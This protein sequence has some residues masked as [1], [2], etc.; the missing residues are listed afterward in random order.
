MDMETGHLLWLLGSL[1]QL[2]RAP[3]D[4]Q[5]ARLRHPG[6]SALPQVLDAI[7]GLGLET[8]L[9]QVRQADAEQLL[10]PCVLFLRPTE[11]PAAPVGSIGA[12]CPAA[13]TPHAPDA[14][15][16]PVHSPLRPC[17]VVR[18]SDERF[19]YF[20]AGS[21]EPKTGRY[22][23]FER[24]FF[25]EACTVRRPPPHYG[26][27]HGSDPGTDEAS[28]SAPRRFGFR[29]FI[30]RLLA[31]RAVWRD[32][33][34]ASL[35]LQ[36]AGLA[37][38]LITQAILDKVI[39]HHA[40]NT[41][42][43]L[44]GALLM[45]LLF[46]AGMGYLRQYLMLH[47]GMRVDAVLASETFSHLVRLPPLYF[48]H[49]PAG[50]LVARLQ[51]IES[52][53]E[54]ISGA[55][56]AAILDLPFALLILA[57]MLAYSPALT[58]LAAAFV[59]AMAA[60]GLAIAP[61]LRRRVEAQF[62]DSARVQ[63]FLTEH[64]SRMAPAKVLQMEPLLARRHDGLFA[65]FLDSGFATRRL[66]AG[67][68]TL[69]SA[70]EQG[71][72]LSILAAGAWL[73]MS[74]PGFTIGMLIAFQMFAGRLSQPVLRLASLWQE[75][76]QAALAVRRLGDFMDLPP[77][78]ET[79]PRHDAGP[80][81]GQVQVENLG[82]RHAASL[83]WLYRGLNLALAP[84]RCVLLLGPSGSGKS[85]LSRLLLGYY[86]PG[87]GRILL[88]GRDITQQGVERLRA[89]FGVVPQDTTLFS[90]SVLDNLLLANPHASIQDA[91][92]A[93]QM[94]GVHEV[95][96]AQPR[97][98]HSEL[99]EGGVGLSG[100]QRQRIAIARALLK[101]ARLLVLDE[102]L[103]GLDPENA[104]QIIATLNR[105]VSQGVGLL[106]IAHE[107]PP[108]LQVHQ[109]LRLQ[110]VPQPPASA[111]DGSA[112]MPAKP[113]PSA[114]ACCCPGAGRL[115]GDGIPCDEDASAS[116][117]IPAQAGIHGV[118]IQN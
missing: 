62:A 12:S 15:T 60:A 18:T 11:D 104:R 5:A 9:R 8:S 112:V 94:A 61:V 20:E 55:A 74:E 52:I 88:D 92:A 118:D 87:E 102:P 2:H 99:A 29:W 46:N 51:G 44:A 50:A 41:L 101:G 32:V 108:G 111:A 98:Y 39:V 66:G 72:N 117:V 109:Q 17:L 7:R 23:D 3:F 6:P 76:Q 83:P 26:E 73:A 4:P 25:P 48:E 91:M 28:A 100:G 33:I 95:I 75:F 97:G 107:P 64:L 53:R 110:A 27:A 67:Y 81:V 30:P 45:L 86:P 16:E 106:Y 103:T 24:D 89:V 105:L 40:V 115:P 54:F 93:C 42:T 70:L 57:M 43:V 96:T 63:A 84:G 85:T 58:G 114:P 80:L 65:R 78:I 36:V 35:A 31:H 37:L 59:G 13:G 56:L 82:F 21:A 77:E 19:L 68:S 10:P 79:Q 1:A 47:T 116:A 49:R 90:G 22:A 14:P 69:I 38:P 113:A 34:L 71:M